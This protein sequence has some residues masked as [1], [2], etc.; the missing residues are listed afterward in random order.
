MHGPVRPDRG[1]TR[2]AS[3]RWGAFDSS[4]RSGC[5]LGTRPNAERY[6]RDGTSHPADVPP[7][8]VIVVI[9]P[10]EDCP[11]EAFHAFLDVLLAGPEPDLDSVG[12][13]EALRELRVDAVA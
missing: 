10:G 13:A 6:L 4:A 7:G 3:A 9:N 12:A 8:S 5:C 1:R 2:S 11:P